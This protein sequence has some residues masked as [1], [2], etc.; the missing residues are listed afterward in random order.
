MREQL[1]RYGSLHGVPTIA[2][3]GRDRRLAHGRQHGHDRVETCRRRV[4]LQHD[5]TPRFEH[6]VDKQDEIID[7]A[8]ADRIVERRAVGIQTG[9][10]AHE[11][12]YNR[13]TVGLERRAGRGVVDDYVCVFGREHFSRAIGADQLRTQPACGDPAPCE[14]LVFGRDNEPSGGKAAAF[15]QCDRSGRDQLDRV[16][17]RVEQ[18]DDVRFE[19]CNPVRPGEADIA[20]AEGQHLHDVLGLQQLRFGARQ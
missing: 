2:E 18:L 7:G 10:R 4:D 5:A 16:E 3:K 15:E 19:L 1:S 9:G 11:H 20:A 14:P 12:V 17:P 6:R 13:E 8:T